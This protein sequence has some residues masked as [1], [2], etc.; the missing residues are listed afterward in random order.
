MGHCQ[1]SHRLLPVPHGLSHGLRNMPPAYFLPALRAGLS[2]LV[3]K[4]KSPTPNGVGL[5]WANDCNIGYQ[6]GIRFLRWTPFGAEGVHFH[7]RGFTFCIYIV[8]NHFLALYVSWFLLAI[9]D[10]WCISNELLLYFHK[11]SFA[12][13]IH[14][15]RNPIPPTNP[16]CYSYYTS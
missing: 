5:F 12:E 7:F 6:I 1:Q 16:I 9:Y 3:S 2:S 4:Q 10:H 11:Y 15:Y 8:C 13:E 14:L